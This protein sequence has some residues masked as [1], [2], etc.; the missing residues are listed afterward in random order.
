MPTYLETTIGLS[1][2][3]R[4]GRADHR[5]ARDDGV[6]ALRRRGCPIGS[7][8]SRC[9]GS[10]W[11]ACSSPAMPMF[12]LMGTGLVGAIDRRSRSSGCCTCRSSP[13]SRRRSRRCS[14]PRCATRRSR[15]PTTWPR[16]SSAA[17]RRGQRVAHRQDRRQ[18]VA[19]VLHDGRVRHRRDRAD[20][21]A[22]DHP[23]ARSTAPQC[24]A[25]P[26]APPQLELRPRPDAPGGS[27]GL[28]GESSSRATAP[29]ASAQMPR[30]L[31]DVLLA[32]TTSA[33]MNRTT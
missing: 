31:L 11:S 1:P 4:A 9:G 22:R 29:T 18:P 15:S 27:V 8:A 16:R 33:G 14:P 21:G 24:P 25:P 20:Q 13:R 26:E 3:S 30:G 17:P 10:R 28:A 2:T 5:H 32:V 12:M 6:P 23:G 19:R 7:A